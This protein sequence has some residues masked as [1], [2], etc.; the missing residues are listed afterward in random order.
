MDARYRKLY[1]RIWQHRVFALLSTEARLVA[2]YLLTGPQSNRIGY[3]RMSVG[4]ASEDLG[5][6]PSACTKLF[7]SVTKAFGW[8]WDSEARV[9][10]VRSW[11]KWNTPEAA[12]NLKGAIKD[13]Y[14]VPTSP[15]SDGFLRELQPVAEALGVV[16]PNP[17]RTPLEPLSNS[18]SGSGS[19]SGSVRTGGSRRR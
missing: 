7:C 15:L 13:Y 10:W 3:Y 19:G 17:S 6:T 1:P 8:E 5:L 12:N 16:V 18:G 4:S 11:W 9:I 14:D 2:L